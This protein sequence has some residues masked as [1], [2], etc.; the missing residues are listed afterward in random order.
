MAAVNDKWIDIVAALIKLTQAGQLTWS[1]KNPIEAF[2]TEPEGYVD[3]VYV[4]EYKNSV[5][6]LYEEILSS[7]KFRHSPLKVLR[8]HA[9]GEV[10]LEIV[11]DNLRAI[12]KFPRITALNDLLAAVKYQVSD[13]KGIFDS[14]IEDAK[15]SVE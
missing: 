14:L 4:T 7:N 2:N 5:I 8:S 10:V 11:D 1:I 15:Q 12:W 3:S 6:R 9:P 13:V